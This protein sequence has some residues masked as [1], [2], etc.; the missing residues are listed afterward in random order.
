MT[1]IEEKYLKKILE[2]FWIW[3]NSYDKAFTYPNLLDR[4]SEDRL[5]MEEC[6]YREMVA[7]DEVYE[8]AEKYVDNYLKNKYQ[9][10]E[11][12]ISDCLRRIRIKIGE[13]MSS[14]RDFCEAFFENGNFYYTPLLPEM[15]IS[16]RTLFML[17]ERYEFYYRYFSVL[18]E[19]IE[20][21][22][23]MKGMSKELK[24]IQRV[25]NLGNLI[26][27]TLAEEDEYFFSDYFTRIIFN[28]N[29]DKINESLHW[30][31]ITSKDE[32]KANFLKEL[33]AL[34]RVF[35][36]LYK[37]EDDWGISFL[38]DYHN[39]YHPG[40]LDDGDICWV[41]D[42]EGQSVLV[43]YLDDKFEDLRTNEVIYSFKYREYDEDSERKLKKEES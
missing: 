34:L 5:Y 10:V 9:I 20:R 4:D 11:N 7:L 36:L 24:E 18:D 8:I 26:N 3:R 2:A 25:Y 22:I 42:E 17:L 1:D 12:P 30:E 21:G 14:E 37:K 16:S 35:N 41:E 27:I 40:E 6:I 13:K 31:I 32:K 29:A 23:K 28:D 33:K 38:R 39:V 43:M 15:Q 19:C